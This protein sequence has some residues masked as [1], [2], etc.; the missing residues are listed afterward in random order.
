MTDFVTPDPDVHNCNLTEGTR[1]GTG[2]TIWG[3][4]DITLEPGE[5]DKRLYFTFTQPRCYHKN[6]ITSA[7][8]ACN[9]TYLISTSSSFS[10][11]GDVGPIWQAI[12]ADSSDPGQPR[13]N[14][15]HSK[16]AFDGIQNHDLVETHDISQNTGLNEF[17]TN[18]VSFTNSDSHNIT[19]YLKGL[20]IIRT[21]D[22]CTLPTDEENQCYGSECVS[23]WWYPEHPDFADRRD[24]VCNLS[25]C[26]GISASYFGYNDE[27]KRIYPGETVTWQWTNELNPSNNYL[28]PE[29][30]L[31]NLNNIALS[32][33]PNGDDVKFMIAVNNGPFVNFYHTQDPSH[34]MAHSVDL[35][36]CS[37]LQEHY[38]DSPG[39]TNYLH[40][41]LD[42]DA[43]A[44]FILCDGCDNTPC[45]E[46]CEGGRVNIYRYYQTKPCCP[47]IT[48]TVIGNGTI[49]PSG[50]IT[51]PKE[52]RT[53][54]ISAYNG[55]RISYIEV[56]GGTPK[57]P[58]D[59]YSGHWNYTVQWSDLNMN[60]GLE[61]HHIVAYFEPIPQKYLNV[62]CDPNQGYTEGATS[63]YY[64]YGTYLEVTAF[65]QSGYTFSCWKVNGSFATNDNP[66]GLQMLTDVTL[67]PVFYYRNPPVHQLTI[68]THDMAGQGEITGDI[69]VD[70]NYV[71]SNYA[72][73]QVTEGNHT[74]Y[75]DNPA[76]NPYLWCSTDFFCTTNYSWG[77]YD[78][79]FEGESYY[80]PQTKYIYADTYIDAWYIP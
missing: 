53:F 2:V 31:F 7:T 30:C 72:S 60:L 64:N 40:L 5:R 13:T 43:G 73:I 16:I 54:E 62:D 39:A 17:G 78:W 29:I 8:T 51:V 3:P 48:S 12:N 65:P 6:E 77:E 18:W 38:N 22:M 36:N 59:P 20:T 4:V 50:P 68:D 69:Y 37:G 49:E 14:R 61:G 28:G 45:P 47:T 80:D 10:G 34:H 21:Y 33:V 23:E 63:G 71:G 74:I 24:Y 1:G 41:H 15:Y 19:V 44:Y 55:Y 56:D 66:I 26:G 76:W 46:Q 75:I 25:N 67:T 58:P 42:S 52:G 70:D 27:H 32:G 57:E 79:I 35:A 9:L 11:F